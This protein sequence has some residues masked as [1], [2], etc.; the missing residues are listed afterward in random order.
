MMIYAD[1]VMWFWLNGA[2]VPAAADA[3]GHPAPDLTACG[4]GTGWWL[5]HSTE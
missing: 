5:V 1:L 3:L 2:I 4:A